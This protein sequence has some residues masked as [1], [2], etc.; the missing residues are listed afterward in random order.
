MPGPISPCITAP[1]GTPQ[2]P[3]LPGWFKPC[4][5]GCSPVPREPLGN[6]PQLNVQG[7]TEPAAQ[8]CLGSQREGGGKDSANGWP[9]T[10]NQ[11]HPKLA[12][13][14]AN[15]RRCLPT[16][17]FRKILAVAAV[18]KP[19]LS[20]LQLSRGGCFDYLF[21]GKCTSPR[22]MFQHTGELVEAKIDRVIA[23]MQARLAKFVAEN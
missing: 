21:F 10:N 12:E 8:A 13:A 19:Q 22:C 18:P 1:R 4:K 9:Y 11:V 5:G 16:V 7:A 15:A 17:N 6:A 2:Y 23:K 14:T 20:S 3:T